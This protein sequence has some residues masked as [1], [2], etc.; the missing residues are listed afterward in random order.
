MLG[1]ITGPNDTTVLVDHADQEAEDVFFCHHGPVILSYFGGF[2]TASS[3][4]MSL[5][6][7]GTPNEARARNNDSHGR[8]YV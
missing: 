2:P 4:K 5:D 8:L 6:W 1:I 7:L 3:G